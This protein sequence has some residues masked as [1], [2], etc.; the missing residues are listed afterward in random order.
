MPK[1]KSVTI[2]S[3]V[4]LWRI[5]DEEEDCITEDLGFTVETVENVRDEGSVVD[6]VMTI[7]DHGLITEPVA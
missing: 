3:V 6:A 5:Q 7:C 1:L 4:K 2:T